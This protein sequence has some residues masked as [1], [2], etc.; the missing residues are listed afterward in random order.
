MI[1]SSRSSSDAGRRM[2]HPVDR[3]VHRAFLLDVGVRAGD[4][5]LGLVI[6]VIGDEILDRIVGEEAL[7]LAVELRGEDLVRREHERRALQRLDHLG[8]GEGLA[9]AGDAEQHLGLLALADC[10]TSSAIACGWS[11]AG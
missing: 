1:T 6:I 4:I 8:H 11:P 9:R 5:G 7:E 2:A 10:S 3:L